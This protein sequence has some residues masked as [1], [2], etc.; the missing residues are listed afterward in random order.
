MIPYYSDDSVT[1]YHGDVLEVLAGLELEVDQVV[2]S[3]PYN[4]GQ[5][6]GTTWKRLENGYAEHADDLDPDQYREW[7]RTILSKLWSMLD[8]A[9]SIY[10]NHKPRAK[11]PEVLLPTELLPPEVLLRQIVIWD[12]GSGF[13]RQ[14]TH[15]VPCHEWILVLAR[16]AFR[17][18][19]LDVGDVWRIPANQDPIHP[20]S[21]P[22][23]LATKAIATTD[24]KLILDPF[25]GSG[26]TLRA[27]KDLGRRAIGIEIS[28][29]YCETI[30][31][32][33]AQEVLAL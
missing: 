18:N 32:R 29:K 12:R 21:F 23:K 8:E 24:A 14:K 10:M 1:L 13:Q 26:T 16:E 25:A 19:C 5:T 17:I 28:E 2:T 11:G 31:G 3:P 27:A 22:L 20:A 6:S 30:V 9:G 7:I 4:L 33:L 15:Y